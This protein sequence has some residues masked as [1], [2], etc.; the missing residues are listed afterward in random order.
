[1]EKNKTT[2]LGVAAGDE[3][4]PEAGGDAALADAS[5]ITLCRHFS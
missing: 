2:I 1:M 3:S 5:K 4:E